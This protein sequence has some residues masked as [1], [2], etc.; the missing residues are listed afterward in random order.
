MA[1]KSRLHLALQYSPPTVGTRRQLW[2][3]RL[4]TIPPDDRDFQLEEV[5]DSVEQSE[6]NGREISNSIN[7]A[8]TLARDEK[9]KLDFKHLQTIIQVWK[10]FGASLEKE[11]KSLDMKIV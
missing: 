3:K 9:K 10:D 4:E 8:L 5:L 11:G 7:T 2:Q 6:M 1:I